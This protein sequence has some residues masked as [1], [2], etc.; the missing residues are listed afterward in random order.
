MSF[1]VSH[2]RAV[3]GQQYNL[4]LDLDHQDNMLVVHLFNDG[5]ICGH[6]DGSSVCVMLGLCLR[7]MTSK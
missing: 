2:Q 3:K 1:D 4:A 5:A 6:Q 7:S